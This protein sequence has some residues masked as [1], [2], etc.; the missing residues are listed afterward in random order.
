[1]DS[2]KTPDYDTPLILGD[3]TVTFV[4]LTYKQ[5][6]DN[7]QLQFEDQKLMQ[8]LNNLPDMTQ[9]QRLEMLSESFRRITEVTIQA[10][11]RSIASIQT[12]DALVTEY[13]YIADFM[14][15][16]EKNIFQQIR[17]HAISLRQAG[18]IKPLNVTC[19]ACENNYTQDFSLDMSNFFETN[20]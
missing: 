13:E 10:I 12:S 16:C 15:N 9:E 20:S 14:H 4:P 2:L 6:N 1:M 19:S 5:L 8:A 17:D 18:D 11:A 7:N 3:L